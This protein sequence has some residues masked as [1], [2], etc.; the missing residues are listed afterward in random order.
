MGSYCLEQSAGRSRSIAVPSMFC[1]I[2]AVMFICAFIGERFLSLSER[3]QLFAIHYLCGASPAQIF[4]SQ[5]LCDALWLILPAALSCIAARILSLRLYPAAVLCPI[6]ALLF[7][8]ST[9]NLVSFLLTFRADQ[10]KLIKG[11]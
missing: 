4:F 11:A 5:L 7:M 10:A 1:A 2:L 3:K 6:L 9:L 8:L